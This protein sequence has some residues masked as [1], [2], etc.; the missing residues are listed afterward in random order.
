MPSSAVLLIAVSAALAA[1]CSGKPAADDRAKP[2]PAAGSAE[3]ATPVEPAAPVVRAAP[4]TPPS[5]FP[6][7]CVAY[8]DLIE[9]LQRCDRLGSA[10]DGMTQAY[11]DL[12]AGWPSV[13]VDRRAEVAAQCK[14]QSE[15][16]HSAAAATCGW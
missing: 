14:T 13:P 12:R 11:A 10:R 2:A 6:P 1:G 4:G 15:S 3:P 16:L 7:E 8:A 9:K 5:D